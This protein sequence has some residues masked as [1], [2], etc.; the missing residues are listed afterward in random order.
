MRRLLLELK[1]RLYN[2]MRIVVGITI[3]LL[4]FFFSDT[5]LVIA[6]GT[7]RLHKVIK[8]G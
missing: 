4:L 1:I 2:K 5:S 7:P 6:I 3:F 8:K